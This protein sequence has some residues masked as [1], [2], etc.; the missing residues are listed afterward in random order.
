MQKTITLIIIISIWLNSSLIAQE[1]GEY[2]N[3]KE[4]NDLADQYYEKGNRSVTNTQYAL[5]EVYYDSAIRLSSTRA[6]YYIARG[7][8]KELEG[9]EMGALV[10]YEAA[11]KMDGTNN[12][13]IFKR[14]LI[15]YKRENYKQAAQDFTYLIT[16]V[17]KLETKAIVFKGVSYDEDGEVLLSGIS[18]VEEMK[19]DIFVHRAMTYEKLGYSTPAMLD[20]DKAIELNELDPNYY[21]YRGMFRLDRGDKEG[22]ITDYRKALKINPHHRNALYNLSFL[23]DD[24]ERDEI[25]KILFGKGDFAKA[26]SKRAFESFQKGNYEQALLDYDSA[27]LIKADNASD[28]M[29]RGIVKSKL[30]QYTD[31]VKDFNSSVYTDNSLVRNYVLI[32]NAYQEMADYNSSIKYYE[33]YINNA[34]PDASVYY[35]LGLAYMKYKKDTEACTQF[36]KAIELGEERAEKPMDKVCF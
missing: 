27:L 32:G 16:N 33:R 13:A 4:K 35:N 9:D 14:A 26:Y 20:Y 30:G 5:A 8:A 34:G 25:N 11:N 21:V 2:S 3:K 1:S 31:A 15:Y 36:R 12:V 24:D 7:Q 28:L 17:E 23:V 29:N 10:D 19:A 18:T 22:A 6:D